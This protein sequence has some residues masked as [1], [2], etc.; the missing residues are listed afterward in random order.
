[1]YK[2]K[3]E[4]V[5]SDESISNPVYICNKNGFLCFFVTFSIFI[6][7]FLLNSKPLLTPHSSPL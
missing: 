7:L 5:S 2:R 4:E 3:S 6:S 1:M